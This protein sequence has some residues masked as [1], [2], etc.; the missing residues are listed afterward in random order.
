MADAQFTDQFAAFQFKLTTVTE[1]DFLAEAR[2]VARQVFPK[3]D[4]EKKGD[5]GF[6]I[7]HLYIKAQMQGV[8]LANAWAQ[9]F[10]ILT[11]R[12]DSSRLA[13]ARRLGYTPASPRPARVDALL[14]YSPVLPALVTFPA[15]AMQFST[16]VV[17][18]AENEVVFENEFP[19]SIGANIPSAVVRMVAGRSYQQLYEATDQD[20]Q[21]VPLTKAGVIEGSVRVTF[22][23]VGWTKVSDF[24]NSGPNDQHFTTR[25]TSEGFTEVLFGD[26]SNGQRPPNGVEGTLD[27]RVGGGE[28]SNIPPE[29]MTYIIAPAAGV[30]GRPTS[31]I[32]PLRG[33]NGQNQDSS[34]II[35]KKAIDGVRT[36]DTIGNIADAVK[37]AENFDGVARAAATL[38]GTTLLVFIIPAGGLPSGTVLKTNL[39]NAMTERLVMGFLLQVADVNPVA[40]RVEVQFTT[41]PGFVSAEVEA[42]VV[43]DIQAFLNPLSTTTDPVTRKIVF[44]RAFKETLHVNDVRDILVQRPEVERDFEIVTL[45]FTTPGEVLDLIIPAVGI[46]TDVGA[47]VTATSRNVQTVGFIPS[48]P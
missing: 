4:S 36:R 30:S 47:V 20:F 40:P 25:L 27:Y 24:V 46:T 37:F 39:Q 1:E 33:T 44:R 5:I 13:H 10:N 32:N 2:A 38:V 11:A 17:D 26:G 35:V 45:S 6:F 43:A 22:L 34:A 15:Y 14:T 19:F 41:R 29:A 21:E 48:V 42:A 9:E 23:S 7:L 18:G 3:W 16:R 8:N 12:E 28:L 31:V